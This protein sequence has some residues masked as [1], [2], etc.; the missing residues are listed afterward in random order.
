MTISRQAQQVQDVLNYLQKEP[1][2]DKN[3]IGILVQ[4][5]GGPSV[6]QAL[7]LKISS[8]VFLSAVF[9][10]GES[11]KKVLSERNV[12]IDTQEITK[13]PRSDGSVTEFGPQIWEDFKKLNLKGKL[14]KHAKFPVLILHGALDTKVSTKDAKQFFRFSQGKKELVIYPE[15]D[16]GFDEVS[17]Q[18]RQEVLRKIV[19]WYTLFPKKS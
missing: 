9:S 7:P 6:I 3:R 5:I 1:L 19:S 8:L 15:G 17:S 11:L 14:E 18:L 10:P 2:V 13:M 16:H 4:S 12:K